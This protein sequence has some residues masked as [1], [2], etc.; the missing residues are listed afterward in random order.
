MDQVDHRG[1]L[2]KILTVAN[3][4]CVCVYSASGEIIVPYKI[5][6]YTNFFM[7]NIHPSS[8]I[9]TSIDLTTSHRHYHI[10]EGG[11]GVWGRYVCVC[12]QIMHTYR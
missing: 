1:A 4:V 10:Q 7:L 11:V 3:L 6:V 8:N 9:K 2:E 5:A 12:G